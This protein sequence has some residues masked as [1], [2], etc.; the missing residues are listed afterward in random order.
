MSQ[1]CVLEARKP[2]LACKEDTEPERTS[3]STIQD[4]HDRC[5]I[6]SRLK[7]AVQGFREKR[8]ILRRQRNA[9]HDPFILA[10]PPEISSHIFLLCMEEWDDQ[11]HDSRNRDLILRNLPTPFL[12]ATVCHGWR[13]LAYS[14]PQLWTRLSFTLAKPTKVPLPRVISDWLQRSGRLPLAIWIFCNGNIPRE[15]EETCVAVVDTVNQHSARWR[16]VVLRN[17]PP[18]YLSQFCGTSP[19]SS[20]YDLE[21]RNSRTA[22]LRQSPPF[23]M[24]SKANP[25]NLIV[26]DIGLSAYSIGWD[27]LTSLVMKHSTVDESTHLMT[28][29]KMIFRHIHLRMLDFRDVW[30]QS[31]ITLMDLLECP[32]LERL[33][34]LTDINDTVADG[35]ISLFRRS[36]S[37]MKDLKLHDMWNNRLTPECFQRLYNAVPYLQRLDLK[38]NSM[39]GVYEVENLFQQLSSPASIQGTP[40]FLPHLKSLTIRV[41][42]KVDF[43]PLP[44]EDGEYPINRAN[45]DRAMW[46][47]IPDIYIR[48]HRKFLILEVHATAVKHDDYISPKISNLIDEG[49]DIRILKNGK[50]DFQRISAQRR[51]SPPNRR[52]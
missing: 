36:G 15:A 21:V 31:A 13:Q 22:G 42:Y 40:V 29:P 37:R 9:I 20:L 5:H 50:D 7:K 19:P 27:N 25:T 23:R 17:I 35:C 8:R 2:C 38:W 12:L 45:E 16:K 34:Y 46:K 26:H 30:N 10:F 24:N 43:R 32:S 18:P 6:L 51:L 14:T 44:R 39:Q 49:F 28:I 41:S 1:P 48:P 47:H 33:N 11:P 52:T 4:F 3:V